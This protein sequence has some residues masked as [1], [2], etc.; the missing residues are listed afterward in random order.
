[1]A[2]I[3]HLL[4]GF[5]NE[6]AGVDTNADTRQECNKSLVMMLGVVLC[7]PQTKDVVY[8]PQV[9]NAHLAKPA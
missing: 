7:L 6:L 8:I 9:G 3:N 4:A 5:L 1:M 2:Q